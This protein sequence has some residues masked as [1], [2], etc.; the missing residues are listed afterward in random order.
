LA[1][2][3]LPDHDA[4]LDMPPLDLGPDATAGIVR[5]PPLVT[6]VARPSL[7]AAVDDDGNEACGVRLPDVAVPLGVWFGWNPETPRVRPAGPADAAGTPLPVELWNLLGGGVDFPAAEILE[8]YGD[9]RRYLQQVEACVVDL[10]ARRHLL[11]EDA[12][13][14]LDRA[15]RRWDETVGSGAEG[16]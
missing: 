6:G 7:V 5:F 15:R 14:L 2:V 1:G 11:P 3:T 16:P 8:R 4:L 13:R 9:H 10:V 12:P